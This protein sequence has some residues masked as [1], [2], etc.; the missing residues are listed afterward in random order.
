MPNKTLRVTPN[1]CFVPAL[2][3]LQ[4][5]PESLVVS[6]WNEQEWLAGLILCACSYVRAMWKYF[7]T[8]NMAHYFCFVLKAVNKQWTPSSSNKKKPPNRQRWSVLHKAPQTE[9]CPIHWPAEGDVQEENRIPK[10]GRQQGMQQGPRELQRGKAP[11][12][13][14]CVASTAKYPLF[15]NGT[16]NPNWVW[17]DVCA[18]SRYIYISCEQ[19]TNLIY[20]FS[21]AGRR[22]GKK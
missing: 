8:T 12:D 11:G 16:G 17:N 15:E 2:G 19:N 21:P 22:P 1:K 4:N 5:T 14:D 20:S 6:Q 9:K 18:W 3:H 10:R 13:H 7:L